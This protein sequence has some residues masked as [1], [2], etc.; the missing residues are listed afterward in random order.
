[1]TQIGTVYG[2]ALYALAREEKA[3]DKILAEMKALQ[4][5]FAQEPG[6]SRLLSAPNLSKEERCRIIDDSFR[7]KL[8]PYVL[9]FLKSLTEKG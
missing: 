8:H 9:N 5:S 3:A 1:M 6:F 2:Q 4:E 7:G